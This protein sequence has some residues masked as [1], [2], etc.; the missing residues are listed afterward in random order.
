MAILHGLHDAFVGRNVANKFRPTQP[1]AGTTAYLRRLFL[2][3]LST[4]QFS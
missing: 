3:E 2:T 1:D 4:S